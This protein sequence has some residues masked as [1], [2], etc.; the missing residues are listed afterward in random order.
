VG[1]SSVQDAS[2]AKVD[3]DEKRKRDD[4]EKGKRD[5]DDD[6]SREENPFKD[7]EILVQQVTQTFFF[8]LLLTRLSF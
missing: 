7:F 1:W 4:D 2:N 6:E 8:F 3:H 5:D